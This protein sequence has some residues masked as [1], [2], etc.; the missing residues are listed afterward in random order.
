MKVL[1]IFFMFVLTAIFMLN[2]QAANLDQEK[3]ITIRKVGGA[4]LGVVITDVGD[5]LK[6]KLGL[7]GGAKIMEVL[8]DS[9]A[10]EI[11]LKEDDII[12]KFE[13]KEITDAEQLHDMVTDYEDEKE[14]KL[15]VNRNG[16]AIEF[17]ATLKP[18][19]VKTGMV[20]VTTDDEEGEIHVDVDVDDEIEGLHNVFVTGDHDFEF[21]SKDKGGFLGVVAKNLKDQLKEY[22]GVENGV[23][24]EEIV[25]D[26]P[27]EKAG[28]KAGDV[29]IQVAEK[30]I[31]DYSDLIRT[32]NFYDPEDEVSVKY[33]RK[34]KANT[35]KVTL[36]EKKGKHFKRKMWKH[37]GGPFFFKG[38]DGDKNFHII[39]KRLKG[40]K[41]ELK[42][43]SEDMKIF[44]I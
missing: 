17:E 33:S 28:L 38:F 15:T 43:I 26:S 10:D 2:C 13:G 18:G 5:E 44:I 31:N 8:D 42:E 32:L 20:S 21:I 37:E 30:K 25:E 34:G 14:V 11:G 36:A 40:L 19:K 7:K 6:E 27:A 4:A 16:E 39:K 29:I 3:T 9:K 41:G 35:V 22:F 1:K 12:V 23:L 24:I